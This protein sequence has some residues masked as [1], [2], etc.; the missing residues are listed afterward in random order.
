MTLFSYWIRFTYCLCLDSYNQEIELALFTFELS[1]YLWE[2]LRSCTKMQCGANIPLAFESMP[3]DFSHVSF[4]KAAW[5]GRPASVCS[6]WRWEISWHGKSP[7]GSIALFCLGFPQQ[8]D[9]ETYLSSAGLALCLQQE[10]HKP[11]ASISGSE[12][13][14]LN[15]K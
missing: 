13:K 14:H 3:Q 1:S 8:R 9:R 2:N 6:E 10:Q 11:A 12:I 7:V 4:K 15:W 5:D